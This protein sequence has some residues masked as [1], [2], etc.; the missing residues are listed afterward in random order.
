M[1][2]TKPRIIFILGPTAVGKSEFAV[3]LAK[4]MNAEIISC[5]S[6]QVYRGMDIISCKPSPSAR[7]RIPHHLIDIIP[8]EKEFNAALYRRYALKAIRAILK[9]GRIPLFVGGTGF[10]A[11][12][13]LDGIFQGP[14]E[15]KKIRKLLYRRAKTG[16]S[17]ALYERLIKVDP[18]AAA[19]IHPN[20]LKRI[21]RALEVYI[22]TKR[23]ISQWQKQRKGLSRDYDVKVYCLSLPREE[24]YANINKRVGQMFKKGLVN[25]VRRLLKRKL[26]KTASCAIGIN[27][28]R[29]YLEG[30]Y[31][32]EQAKDLIRKHTR[33]YAKRQLTWFRKDRRLIWVALRGFEARR[34]K[35]IW[36]SGRTSL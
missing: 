34:R 25:E 17:R 9:K 7:K 11:G 5:D 10:Y 22:K 13:V 16:G 6:M 35:K 19:K 8:P 33:Q 23:P 21:I 26:S 1:S 32:L 24:L 3:K 20:D 4:R 12:A 36:T 29:G 28:V 30:M 27:E 14:G 31:G 18:E 15:D 2:E